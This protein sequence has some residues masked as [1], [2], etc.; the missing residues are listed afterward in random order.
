MALC[1]AL[2]ST[3]KW[4]AVTLLY[5]ESGSGKTTLAL[6]FV[7]TFCLD[8]PCLY[9]TTDVDHTVERAEMMK[10]KLENI[11][12][13]R[14]VSAESLLDVVLR[15]DL[16]RFNLIVIDP[17]SE[18]IYVDELPTSIT[19]FAQAILQRVSELFGLPV[20]ETSQP[21]FDPK[22]GVVRPRGYKH[23]LFWVNNLIRLERGEQGQNKRRAVVEAPR[24][25]V[26]AFTI[27]RGGV[28]WINC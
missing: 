8:G 17:I 21:T 2:L 9:V 22:D 15:Q 4:P 23:L 7:K 25:A 3:L 6:E 28:R 24:E 26:F 27:E 13:Y 1:T 5:G 19:L 18:Y 11:V 10:I 20:I 12:M 16:P 14:L